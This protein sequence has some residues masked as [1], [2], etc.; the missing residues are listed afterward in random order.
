MESKEFICICCPKGCHITIDK[1]GKIS[2]YTCLRGL[3]Y[4]KEESTNP[5]RVVTS[6]IKVIDSDKLTCSIKTSIAIPKDKIFDVMKMIKN[7]KLKPPI[8]MHQ[9]LLHNIFSSGA[10]IITTEE[11][12]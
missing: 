8:R 11:I 1:D 9:V 2:G 7:I 5:K 3:S 4:V 12:N 10:D 6:T